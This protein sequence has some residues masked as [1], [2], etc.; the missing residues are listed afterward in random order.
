[1]NQVNMQHERELEI[2]L[3]PAN[4]KKGHGVKREENIYYW[5]HSGE[6]KSIHSLLPR[7]CPLLTGELNAKYRIATS[8]FF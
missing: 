7:Q 2:I 6:A 3:A 8:Y 1:M 4:I 5:A